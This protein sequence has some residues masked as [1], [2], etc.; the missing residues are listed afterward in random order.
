VFL[1]SLLEV[2][3]WVRSLE[4]RPNHS[5]WLQT[6]TDQFYTGFV[7]LL[8]DGRYLVIEYKGE[9]RWNNEDSREKRIIGEVCTKR[10]G[11]KCIFIM[12]RGQKNDEVRNK[13]V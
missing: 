7:C 4:R 11:E 5:F 12:P 2:K 1:D 13:V 8:S 9:D 10:S 6:P 3:V